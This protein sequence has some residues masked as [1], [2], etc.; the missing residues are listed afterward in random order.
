MNARAGIAVPPEPP[1]NGPVVEP[2]NPADTAWD[3]AAVPFPDL[4]PQDESRGP[5]EA[6]DPVAVPVREDFPSPKSSVFAPARLGAFLSSTLLHAL[7]LSL[8][9]G[10]LVAAGLAP[11]EET[12]NIEIVLEAPVK[13]AAPVQ[14]APASAPA[15]AEN[16]PPSVPEAEAIP[17]E[18]HETPPPATEGDKS[19]KADADRPTPSE[20]TERVTVPQ[21]D[22]STLSILSAPPFV[23]APAEAP[24]AMRG[25]AKKPESP[26]RSKPEEERKPEAARRKPVV[27]KTSKKKKARE[28]KT[29]KPAIRHEKAL[30]KKEQDRK[31]GIE[32]NGAAPSRAAAASAGEKAAYARKLLTHVQRYKRYPQAAERA[33]ITG[34]A[35]LSIT[36]DRSGSLR[37]ARLVSSAGSALLDKEAMEVAHRA[38]PY[39][40]PP[41]G[42]GNATFSFIVTLRFER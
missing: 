13:P 22:Q 27:G 37:G 23:P 40:A 33:G 29:E 1:A 32:R 3:G 25:V 39:P 12:V 18:A 2:E 7:L 36:I 15:A 11:P 17:P 35:R 10:T 19:P 16:P 9:A 31:T 20:N 34:A 42:V 28:R 4:R 30:P 38:S 26:Q 41:P 5:P 8:A 24:T 14:P 21:P 6:A